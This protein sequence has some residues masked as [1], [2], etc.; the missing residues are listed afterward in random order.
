MCSHSS[1]TQQSHQFET[2]N[3][4]VIVIDGPRYSE[5]WGDTLHR[6]IPHFANDLAPH[7]VVF[8]NF[9][10]DGYTYTTSGHTA[11]CTGT[12]EQ[13]DNR[14]GKDLPSYPSFLQY[15][16]K[17]NGCPSSKGW[18][19]TSKD[20]LAILADCRDR[21]W[22]QKYNPNTDCG[23]NGLGTGYRDD[24]ITFKRVIR[25]LAKEKPSVMLVNLKE[26]DYSGHAGDWPN[27]LKGL[28]NS[29]SLVWE[30]W[31]FLQAD[32]FYKESTTLFVT[33]D[34]GRHLDHVKD[35]FV[36]HGDD[37][38][39]CRHISLFAAG[40]DFKKNVLENKYYEQTSITATISMLLNLNMKYVKGKPMMSV[41][42]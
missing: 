15:Y 35:G 26:P 34:H 6:Y 36:S 32:P 13:L 1:T 14:T 20:K 7:G 12:Q 25:V 42:K 21:E 37:C 8:T 24:S 11:I 40:P 4:I 9:H 31:K 27:Y 10:N 29:D 33:N 39:G 18:V 5:T 23:N 17:K 19:I 30:V 22:H 2:K 3:V 41:L 16:L 38:E 28:K